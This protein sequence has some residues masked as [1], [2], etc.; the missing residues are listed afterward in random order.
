[1]ATFHQFVRSI[2]RPFPDPYIEWHIGLYDAATT[3][4]RQLERL[5]QKPLLSDT[6]LLELGVVHGP[7]LIIDEENPIDFE[8][9]YFSP[10][11]P[12]VA[13]QRAK[14]WNEVNKWPP[15]DLDNPDII[16]N[17]RDYPIRTNIPLYDDIV[18]NIDRCLKMVDWEREDGD[19]IEVSSQPEHRPWIRFLS[20]LRTNFSRYNEEQ[21]HQSYY[22]RFTL[23]DWLV[24]PPSWCSDYHADTEVSHALVIVSDTITPPD[25][26]LLRSEVLFA[27]MVLREG[28]A[29]LFW[30][31]HYTLPVGASTSAQR[32]FT[33]TV[34]TFVFSY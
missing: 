19:H 27:A 34:S 18:E 8:P 1:M 12:H 5:T 20:P 23:Y 9:R 11:T 24:R 16:V 15:L 13:A 6:R 26:R 7:E 22:H 21:I 33:N 32:S 25:S 31:K 14:R 3:L 4:K 10:D 30:Q 29:Q 17:W 28:L 2:P